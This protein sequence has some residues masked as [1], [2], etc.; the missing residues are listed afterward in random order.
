M[1]LGIQE[2][3]EILDF[4]EGVLKDVNEAKPGGVSRFELVR[5]AIGN[6]PAAIKAGIGAG[7]SLPELADVDSAEGKILANKAIAIAN[8]VM[9]LF[10]ST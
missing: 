8:L 1:A 7:S 10:S 6:A 5:I 2:T 4:L 3:T 9:K